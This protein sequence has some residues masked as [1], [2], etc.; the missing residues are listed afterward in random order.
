VERENIT[1]NVK[2]VEHDALMARTVAVAGWA[3]NTGAVR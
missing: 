3:W 2:A 1:G